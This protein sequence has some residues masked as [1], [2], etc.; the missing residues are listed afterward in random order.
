MSVPG[1]NFV[2]YECPECQHVFIQDYDFEDMV[3]YRDDK[4][5]EK[6]HHILN[7]G[8]TTIAGYNVKLSQISDN[9]VIGLKDP[10]IWNMVMETAALSEDFLNKY[11]DLMDT[12]SFIDSIY[13]IDRNSSEL[14]PI[15]FDY[16]KNDPA[17]STARKIMILSEIIRTLSSDNYFDLRNQIAQLFSSSND[18]TYKIPA[19]KCP[20]CGHEFPD[21][22]TEG[23]RM[24]FT[25]HQ[26]GALGVI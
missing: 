7:S 1:S 19:A 15:S 3:Q 13:V 17:K 6:I 23:M 4:A 8:N 24:L 21:E 18:M 20:K 26:L 9:Y 12:M 22:P 25:R 14:K 10:S 16:D 5:K 2:H 11:E